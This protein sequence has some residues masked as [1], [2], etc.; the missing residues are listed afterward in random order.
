MKAQK[1]PL[2]DSFPNQDSGVCC[3]SQLG[4]KNDISIYNQ[5]SC[6]VSIMLGED[7]NGNV[8][9]NGYSRE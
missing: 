9:P 1:S 3:L 7:V 5:I 8:G 4:Y 2:L 6:V